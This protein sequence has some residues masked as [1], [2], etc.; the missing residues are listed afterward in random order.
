[1][2]DEELAIGCCQF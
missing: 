2:N 1:L